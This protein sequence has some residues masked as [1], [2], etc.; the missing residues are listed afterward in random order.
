MAELFRQSAKERSSEV[1]VRTQ[2]V[3]RRRLCGE[4]ER[5]VYP[6]EGTEPAKAPK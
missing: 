6:V 3:T 4:M 2:R 5:K 1:S